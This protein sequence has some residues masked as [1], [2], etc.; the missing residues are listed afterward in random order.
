M[1]V[2]YLFPLEKAH[3]DTQVY[4]VACP[5]GCNSE[6]T[7]GTEVTQSGQEGQKGLGHSH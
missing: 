3:T 7:R 5:K 4:K 2:L 6:G 1:A